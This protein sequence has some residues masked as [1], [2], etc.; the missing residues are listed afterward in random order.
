MVY[1]RLC[2]NAASFHCALFSIGGNTVAKFTRNGI[3]SH[4]VSCKR[5]T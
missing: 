4:L 3:S 1:I 5:R 2:R